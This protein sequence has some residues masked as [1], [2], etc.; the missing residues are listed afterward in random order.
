[1]QINQ[2]LND[3]AWSTEWPGGHA[4]AAG[5]EN[6][7]VSP[8]EFALLVAAGIAG[9][10]TGSI[11]GLASLAT[12]PALLAVGLTPVSANVTNTVAL[13]FTGVGSVL[14]SRQE[15]VGQAPRIKTLAPIAALGAVI[16][17]AL[18]LSTPAGGFEKIVPWLLGL[19]SLTILIPRRPAPD[20]GAEVPAPD[21]VPAASW[22][23]VAPV[24]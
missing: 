11:A 23:A 8:A 18:L 15:L 1:M 12:Y 13:I 3:S 16:G 9:G 10:L 5:C 19:A 6:R 14:G 7:Q 20:A 17:A 22:K 2:S 4:R 21:A 24:C